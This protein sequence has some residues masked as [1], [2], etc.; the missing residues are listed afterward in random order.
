MPVTI[1]GTTGITTP[2]LDSTA[3]ISANSVPFGKGT[4]SVATNTAAGIGALSSNTSG[5]DT[6]AYGY[7]AG[8]SHTS[9]GQA[10]FAGYQ[11][12]YSNTT[13]YGNS[14]FGFNSLRSATTGYTNT[15]IGR[16]A[17]FALT[18]GFSNT[19]L[20]NGSGE[21]ITTGNSN[22]VVGNYTGNQGGLDIRTANNHIVLSDGDG[23]PTAYWNSQGTLSGQGIKFGTISNA[24]TNSTSAPTIASSYLNGANGVFYSFF[25]QNQSGYPYTY[26]PIFGFN[27]TGNGS[28]YSY[29]LFHGYSGNSIYFRV[30]DGGGP[31]TWGG[32]YSFN[33]TAVSDVRTKENVVDSGSVI[34]QLMRTRIV[35]F[36]Y[37]ANSGYNDNKR[38]KGVIAQEE[39]NNIPDV[40]EYMG[41]EALPDT[42][43][44]VK[45]EKYVPYLVKAFQEHE[46]TIRQL[47]SEIA[48]LKG[49]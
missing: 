23:N 1:N 6:T 20:G 29:Q 39:L 47:K 22:V 15:A 45:Y 13:G 38:H 42:M 41:D 17:L 32:W 3:D 34:D 11:S 46:E 37:N 33:L 16:R 5:V 21:A 26:G 48:A 7:Q 8:F 24:P 4:N 25:V 36:D 12:G 30:G 10:T 28:G 31:D 49:A 43:L 40:V 18:T 9:A 2:D 19:A 27:E 14:A 44:A 35:D